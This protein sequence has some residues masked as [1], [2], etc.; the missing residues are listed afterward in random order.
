MQITG[1]DRYVRSGTKGVW[2]PGRRAF[3]DRLAREQTLRC[4]GRVLG[5]HSSQTARPVPGLCSKLCSSRVGKRQVG[6]GQDKIAI[7]RVFVEP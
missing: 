3:P 5:V 4:L 6:T 2:D 1:L 7:R